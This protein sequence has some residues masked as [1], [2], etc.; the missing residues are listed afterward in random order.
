MAMMLLMAW[1]EPAASAPDAQQIKPVIA[2]VD[3]RATYVLTD[4]QRV[5]RHTARWR[6]NVERLGRC[7]TIRPGAHWERIFSFG[8]LALMR[9]TPPEPGLPPLYFRIDMPPGP[10]SA[11]DGQVSSSPSS[12]SSSRDPVAPRAVIAAKPTPTRLSKPSRTASQVPIVAKDEIRVEPLP[13]LVPSPATAGSA[14]TP[15]DPALPVQPAPAHPET[16]SPDSGH[17]YAVGFALVIFLITLLLAAMALLLRFLLRWS[18]DQARPV[19]PIRAPMLSRPALTGQGAVQRPRPII[20][21]IRPSLQRLP[22]LQRSPDL[23]HSVVRRPAPA[24]IMPGMLQP[25]GLPPVSEIW[26]AEDEI[27]IQRHFAAL[28]LREAGWDARI[29]SRPGQRQADVVA[30]REG[31]IMV[32]RCLPD[33]VLVDEQA[34]EEVCIAREREQADVAVILSSAA[35]TAGARQ[36]AVQTGVDL[37]HESELRD[38]VG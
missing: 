10:V 11:G 25:A 35:V 14:A 27:D 5:A 19:I 7:F 20:S 37:L 32:L 8:G 1:N 38:F 30:L 23:Q 6:N 2:C 21:R 13:P 17:G 26:P 16:N 18:P 22:G 31:R 12:S 34:V 28:L 24:A 4:R 15:L 29:H 33:E 36:L 3:A 9:R